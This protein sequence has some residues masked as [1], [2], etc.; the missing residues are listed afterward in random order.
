[1]KFLYYDQFKCFLYIKSA[2]LNF[3]ILFFLHNFDNFSK[4]LHILFVFITIM[5]A[6]KFTYF[7]LKH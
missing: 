1:M 7:I 5:N 6:N 2:Y 3:L 4:E